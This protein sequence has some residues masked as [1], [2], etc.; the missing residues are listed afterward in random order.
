MGH[1]V[2][3]QAE[4]IELV[5]EGALIRREDRPASIERF[6]DLI[7]A[8]EGIAESNKALARA[9]LARSQAQL[10]VMATLQGL[11]RREANATKVH[12]QPLDLTPLKEVLLQMQAANE[13]QPLAYQFD[14]LRSGEGGPMS[15]VVATPIAQTK[16]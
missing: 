5:G 6:G 11:V 3:S 2:I 1:R 4:L 8:L 16:H 10:E 13:R 14:I 12:S 15:R 7:T 9:D